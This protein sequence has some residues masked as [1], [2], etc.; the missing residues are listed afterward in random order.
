MPISANDLLNLYCSVRPVLAYA[1]PVWHFSPTVAQ[2]KAL[3]C[4][5][6][7]A[8]N[9][10]FSSAIDYTTCLIIAGVDTLAARRE[11]LTKRFFRR[12]VRVSII[13]YR[14]ND[15]D[16]T[17]KLCHLKTF[18]SL[19]VQTERFRKTFIPHWLRYYQ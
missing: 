10:M 11:Y 2:T 14:K 19:T 4:L 6:K 12:R 7:R 9:T 17:N 5:Q 8:M 3:E 13:C 1:S 18:Q 16:I 15:H